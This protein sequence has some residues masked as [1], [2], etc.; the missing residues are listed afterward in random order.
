[1]F[2]LLQTSAAL[3][4]LVLALLP[5]ESRA[6]RQ[7]C[8]TTYKGILV[9]EEITAPSTFIVDIYMD[10]AQNPI[11]IEVDRSWGPV[12]VD[13]FYTLVKERYYNC[14]SFYDVIVSESPKYAQIGMAGNAD[15]TDKWNFN[16]ADESVNVKRQLNAKYTL[17]YVP[18]YGYGTRSTYFMINLEDNYDFDK[19]GLYPFAKVVGGFD[20]LEKV[21]GQNFPSTGKFTD[22]NLEDYFAHGNKWLLYYFQDGSIPLISK[23]TVR[24]EEEKVEDG[25]A[26]Q[27]ASTA[28]SWAF[29][30]IVI[31]ISA[32]AV[33]YA[34]IYIVRRVRLQQQYD[35]M[36][37]DSES[38]HKVVHLNH[39]N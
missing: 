6:Q 11:V 12:G 37:T 34:A 13:H 10:G 9:N 18:S 28:G 35:T 19:S 14:A 29:G 2:V 1:M 21:F 4:V 27:S 20:T 15:I 5:V 7:T 39:S 33:V 22:D 3:A 31:V 38:S 30:V 36:S 16:I 8:T 26:T 24:G 23:A 32:A 25:G 17:T